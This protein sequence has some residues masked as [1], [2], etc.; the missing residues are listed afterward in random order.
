MNIIKKF[1][2][3]IVILLFCIS[4]PF[5]IKEVNAASVSTGGRH[6]SWSS[7]GLSSCGA[8]WNYT[9]YKTMGNGN[10]AYC[11]EERQTSPQNGVTKCND[12]NCPYGVGQG[13]KDKTFAGVA[14][15]IIEEEISG[16]DKQYVYTVAT[17]NSYMARK[18]KVLKADRRP[19]DFLCKDQAKVFNKLY[20]KI[21]KTANNIV[22]MKNSDIKISFSVANSNL[23]NKISG[24]NYYMSNRVTVSKTDKVNGYSTDLLVGSTDGRV[25][26]CS[27]T[28]GVTGCSNTTTATSFYVKCN[29]C[30]ANENISITANSKTS[31]KYRSVVF[32]R[33]GT[34]EQDVAEREKKK[35]IKSIENNAS[36]TFRTAPEPPAPPE[37]PAPT[38]YN[39]NFYKINDRGESISG[40]KFDVEFNGSKV[41][42]VSNSGGFYSFSTGTVNPNGK[43][44]KIT[45]TSSPSGYRLPDDRVILNNTINSKGGCFKSSGSSGTNDVEVTGDD[46]NYCNNVEKKC[47]LADTNEYVTGEVGEGSVCSNISAEV[48]YNPEEGKIDESKCSELPSGGTGTAPPTTDAGTT[49][50]DASTLTDT[51]GTTTDTTTDTTGSTEPI[52]EDNGYKKMCRVLDTATNK[53]K[54]V[55]QVDGKCENSHVPA[56]KEVC[57]V[58][59]NEVNLKYCDTEERANYY[60]FESSNNT[61]SFTFSNSFNNVSISKKAITG[62]E[63]VEGAVLKICTDSSYKED[64]EKC[65]PA[66]NIDNVDLNW[67]SG[68]TAVTVTGLPAGTYHLVEV[69]PPFGYQLATSVEFTVDANGDYKTDGKTTDSIVLKDTLTSLSVS[70]IDASSKKELPGAKLSIC[71]STAPSDYPIESVDDSKYSYENEEGVEEDNSDQDVDSSVDDTDDTDDA[72]NNDIEMVVSEEGECIPVILQDGTRASWTSENTPKQIIG[73]P[74]GTYYLVE[75][76]APAGYATAESILF[77]LKRDGTVVDEDG[78]KIDSNKLVMVDRTIEEVKTGRA[79]MIIA[80]VLGV[81]A[82]G[83]GT[84][85]Y[86]RTTGNLVFAGNISDKIRKRKIHK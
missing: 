54:Y 61:F 37:T 68:S 38:T 25:Q 66:K 64:K 52:P 6:I 45:E 79:I 24:T 69:I 14:I 32:Y 72:D 43:N 70:K 21:E 30:N 47:K 59:N 57:M 13:S 75:T 77:T 12:S 84:Y 31:A 35:V 63:E 62:D 23:M 2:V 19:Q 1:S 81:A 39:I 46:V 53:Y 80:T 71:Y 15:D 76:T 51:T 17:L 36:Y 34:G 83:V 9:V 22:N 78:N 82:I 27:S 56:G 29:G 42:N 11:I 60:K 33:A 40:A 41:N 5:E 67:I 7:A 58:G 86:T 73:L 55:D 18:D 65:E 48:C 26:F 10:K 8:K 49:P 16:S 50:T 20:N 85:Y 74:A 4:F 44:I 3:F 28:N